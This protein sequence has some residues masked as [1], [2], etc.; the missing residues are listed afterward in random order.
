MCTTLDFISTKK[1]NVAICFFDI[2]NAEMAQWRQKSWSLEVQSQ[3]SMSKNVWIFL[4]DFFIENI[5]LGPQ[6]FVKYI[7]FNN[8][9]FESILLLKWRPIGTEC[10][11]RWSFARVQTYSHF[12]TG[13]YLKPLHISWGQIHF[14]PEFMTAMISRVKPTGVFCQYLVLLIHLTTRHYSSKNLWKKNSR[15]FYRIEQ[16]GRAAV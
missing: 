5:N 4:K 12:R 15:N 2:C 13:V 7:F 11:G 8:F 9:N 10:P 6:F 1:L 14:S 16:T 3:F